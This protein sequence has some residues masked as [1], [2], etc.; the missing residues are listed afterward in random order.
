MIKS[1]L[2]A[3]AKLAPMAHQKVSLAHDKTT[4]IVFDTSDPGTG[5]TAV[6]IWSYA[7]R[8]RKR[9]AGCLLILAPRSLLTSAWANDF[10][11][12]APDMKVSVATAENREKAFAAEAD[13]YITNVDAVKWLA[14][15]PKGFLAKF[16]DLVIDESP[17]YKHHASQR[18]R[19][20]AKISKY[21]KHRACLTGTPNG[22]TIC[23]VWHQALLLDGG[24]RLGPSF[25]AFRVS[26][27]V[28]EQV[29]RKAEA[30]RWVDKDGAEE[31]VFGL[32]ADITVRH[33]FEDCV[34]IPPH[35]QQVI[36]YK[37]PPKVRKVYDQ[38][39]RDHLLPLLKAKTVTAIS[40]VNA[41]AVGTKLLQ[42]GSGA[43]YDNDSS[44]HDIDDDRIKL[45]LDLAEARKHTLIFYLWDHQ[46]DKLI[47]EAEARKLKYCAITA[48]TSDKA[49]D[50]VVAA[51]Q[52]GMY[53]IMFAHPINAAHGLTLTRGTATI[54]PGPTANLEHWVQGNKRQHR[55]GQ[56]QKTETLVVVADTV[57]EQR[58]YFDLLMGKNKRMT[59]FLDL[60]ASMTED[61]RLAT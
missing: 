9:R 60:F 42:I 53:R 13:V 1:R 31:A 52:A 41:A 36:A 49:R 51:Y 50:A 37:L 56:T 28:P 20:A 21:F 4:P 59:T 19:A 44:V 29:G 32:L 27:S 35:S 8:R 15:K 61:R 58:V 17:A 43:V 30:V 11:K 25:Y 3:V 22:N 5:K 34:D 10:E 18:S 45:V 6:R 14:M 48:G 46:R 38:M 7:E 2:R 54:W 39:E 47:A 57:V 24:Q 40:A 26:V 16:T 23:D 12:F 55:I 33:K